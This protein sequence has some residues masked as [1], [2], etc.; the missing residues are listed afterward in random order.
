M[1]AVLY[2]DQRVP[3]DYRAFCLVAVGVAVPLFFLGVI[4]KETITVDPSRRVISLDS[5]IGSHVK[6]TEFPFA[7][8]SAAVLKRRVVQG[9]NRFVYYKVFIQLPSRKILLKEF[10][11]FDDA[12]AEEQ[13]IA[14]LLSVPI[15]DEIAQT[16][17]RWEDSSRS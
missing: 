17:V 3:F 12:Q 15:D 5:G 1:I 6:H 2:R 10:L 4:Y 14:H 13:K 11:Y 16:G 7:E 9:R 8:V